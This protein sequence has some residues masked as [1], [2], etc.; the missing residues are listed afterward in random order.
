MSCECITNLKWFLVTSISLCAH[1]QHTL[2]FNI[3]PCVYCLKLYFVIAGMLTT[4]I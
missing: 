1:Y 3:F 2:I 4:L